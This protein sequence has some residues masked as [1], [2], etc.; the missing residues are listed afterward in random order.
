MNP[1]IAHTN[2]RGYADDTAPVMGKPTASANPLTAGASPQMFNLTQP[3]AAQPNV[4]PLMRGVAAFAEGFAPEQFQ[5]GRDRAIKT[6]EDSQ[7]RERE[8]LGRMLSQAKA[9]T[10]KGLAIPDDAQMQQFFLQNADAIAQSTGQDVRQAIQGGVNR[11]QL[12]QQLSG[13]DAMLQGL[14]GPGEPMSEYQKAQLAQKEREL[15]APMKMG[16]GDVLGRVGENDEFKEIFSVPSAARGANIQTKVGRNGNYWEF[17]PSS[18]SWT[19]SGIPAPESK[20]GVTINMPGSVREAVGPDGRPIFVGIDP[21]NP[22]AGFQTIEGATPASTLMGAETRGKF[23]SMAPNAYKSIAKLRELFSKEGDD[24]LSGV[25]DVAAQVASGIPFVG[26]PIAR[27]IGGQ[28]WQDFD[29][30]WNTIELGVHIPSGAAVTPSEAKRFLRANKP[31][32]NES[33]ETKLRKIDN[34]ERFYKGLEAG[35]RGDFAALDA[36]V[37]SVP[38][39]GQGV[40]STQPGAPTQIQLPADLDP[41]E[42]AMVE[43]MR[44][45]GMSDAEIAAVVNGQ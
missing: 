45:E 44:A 6:Q 33:D 30:A 15:S 41:E 37:K 7:S 11:Q 20:S 32:L 23:L 43:Q 34:I 35:F 8:Q 38:A 12:Q 22:E 25:D 16:P 2:P 13:I 39:T 31:A 19:D 1:L 40:T 14:Q 18:G 4:N 29:Q 10:E 5:A 28:N 27:G 21:Q 3:K 17:D 36:L 24:P 9:W 26:E 42:Q